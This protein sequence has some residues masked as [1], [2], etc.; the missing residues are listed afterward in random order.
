MYFALIAM[1]ELS[2]DK[3]G[4]SWKQFAGGGVGPFGGVRPGCERNENLVGFIDG[5]YCV[6]WARRL[7]F[8]FEL[9][10]FFF[11]ML[12]SRKCRSMVCRSRK[13]FTKFP[14]RLF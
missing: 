9:F 12:E 14:A 2:L 13:F 7:A 1:S 10:D 4:L 8:G 3:G 11:V 5:F 6:L